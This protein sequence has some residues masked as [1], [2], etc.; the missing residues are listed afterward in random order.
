MQCINFLGRQITEQSSPTAEISTMPLCDVCGVK[1]YL[2]QM[3][4]RLPHKRIINHQMRGGGDLAST[5]ALCNVKSSLPE[6]SPYVKSV[7]F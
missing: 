3:L 7:I 4:R 6:A 5:R 2:P 1:Y